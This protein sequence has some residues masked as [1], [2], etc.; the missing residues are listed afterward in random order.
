MKKKKKSFNF[1][2]ILQEHLILQDQYHY[3]VYN[4]KVQHY[5]SEKVKNVLI[6]MNL[7]VTH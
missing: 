2:G 1:L 6:K 4:T 7:P 5:L 3:T